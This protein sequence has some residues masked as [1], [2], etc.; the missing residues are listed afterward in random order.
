M[1]NL[2]KLAHTIVTFWLLLWIG[3][4]G[5]SCVK[6]RSYWNEPIRLAHSSPEERR[7]LAYGDQLYQF[8]KFC[9]EYVPENFTYQIAGLS[10][11]SIDRARL[12]YLL[13]PR[14]LS[15]QPDFIIVYKAAGFQKQSARLVASFDSDSYILD[16]RSAPPGQ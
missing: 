10:I 8:F 7:A 12:V 11:D 2:D 13:Y 16:A 14:T 3:L 1:A 5:R 9:A 4:L 6:N 15:E